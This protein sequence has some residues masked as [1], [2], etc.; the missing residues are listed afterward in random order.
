MVLEYIPIVGGGSGRQASR[1]DRS[2]AVDDLVVDWGPSITD[3]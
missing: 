1:I 3:R 2:D